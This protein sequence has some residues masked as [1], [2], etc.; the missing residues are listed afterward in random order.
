MLVIDL[1]TNILCPSG[2]TYGK[3]VKSIFQAPKGKLMVYS[4]FNSLEDYIS[5]LLSKDTNKMKVYL[6]HDI[7][8]IVV[9]DGSV[10]RDIRDDSLISHR[11]ELLS[12]TKFAKTHCDNNGAKFSNDDKFDELFKDTF[13]IDDKLTFK[14]VKV[15]R[16]S[17]YDGHSLRA[18]S[19]F[20]EQLT[21]I[22]GNVKSINSIKK[23]HDG[24]RGK[25]KAPTFMMTY[26]GSEK[27]VDEKFGFGP[28]KS[29]EIYNNYHTLY[30][31]SDDYVAR[32]L[33]EAAHLG[34]VVLA[35]GLKLR[36]PLLASTVRNSKYTARGAS[37]DE[38]T[39]GN[40]MGQSYGMLNNRAMIA[41]MEK[42][43]EHEMDLLIFPI[44]GIH[45]ASYY[46]V[47]DDIDV[48]KFLNDNLIKEM[49][50]QEDPAI[51]HDEVKLG[52]ELDICFESW[53]DAVTIPNFASNEEIFNAYDK[54]VKEILEDRKKKA[55]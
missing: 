28:K 37:E 55:A 25:S 17:K 36:C 3:L 26:G 15:G 11:G 4:D 34:Y 45:D 32:R 1:K 31:E 9:S 8:N 22:V 40:A 18:F 29:K 46:I 23:L 39:L 7:Y 42:V 20:P 27:G 24:L 48:V 53:K 5:A 10:Y 6:G 38:R 41:T 49:Q 47:I 44:A 50:W 30:V 52:A 13:E 43:D 2:S 12:L 19:Y 14:L 54:G 21:D 33:D 16:S 51:A 35:F